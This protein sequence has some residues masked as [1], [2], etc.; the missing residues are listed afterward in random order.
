MRPSGQHAHG[1]SAA[2]F[3]NAGSGGGKQVDGSWGDDIG[4]DRG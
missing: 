1:P 3:G 4:G 2:S